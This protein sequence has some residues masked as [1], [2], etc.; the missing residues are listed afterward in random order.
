[1]QPPL[2]RCDVALILLL[3]VSLSWYLAPLLSSALH[4]T[5]P[6]TL[7]TLVATPPVPR[8]FD[9]TSTRSCS[10]SCLVSMTCILPFVCMANTCCRT[11][12][13][14]TSRRRN[15]VRLLSCTPPIITLRCGARSPADSLSHTAALDEL[16][17]V[18]HIGTD[19]APW[20]RSE[21]R[22]TAD[23]LL[24]TVVQ[25]LVALLPELSQPLSNLAL[26]WLT[27]TTDTHQRIRLMQIFVALR[28]P[29]D[30]NV[31]VRPCACF[32]TRSNKLTLVACLRRISCISFRT[33]SARTLMRW[34]WKFCIRSRLSSVYSFPYT[35]SHSLSLLVTH[36]RGITTRLRFTQGARS[37]AATAMDR[38]GTTVLG[39][40]G[41]IRRWWRAATESDCTLGLPRGRGLGYGGGIV[42]QELV[43]DL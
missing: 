40:H 38:C 39:A 43:G 11:S 18:I 21:F 29:I 4:A 7:V 13:Q 3:D 30:A 37:S 12:C 36:T 28:Q 31:V 8:L 5:L 17:H 2:S 19:T 20:V 41:R 22:C 14:P 34:R 16:L 26:G 27:Q 32:I 6:S 15:S 9:P 25:Q 1:M 35:P 10:R 42:A 23:N 33:I 24:A